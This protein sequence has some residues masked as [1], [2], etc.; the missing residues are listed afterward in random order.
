MES[1]NE[2]PLGVSALAGTS[3]NIDKAI[4]QKIKF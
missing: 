4:Q 1:L 3:F 2:N